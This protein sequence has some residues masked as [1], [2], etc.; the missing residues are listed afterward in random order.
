MNACTKVNERKKYAQII[1]TTTTTTTKTELVKDAGIEKFK[2][3]VEQR[4]QHHYDQFS[5]AVQ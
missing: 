1:T 3:C 2:S 4:L 5:F